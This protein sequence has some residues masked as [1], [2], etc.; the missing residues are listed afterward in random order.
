MKKCGIDCASG[1][2][3][4]QGSKVATVKAV[5]EREGITCFLCPWW[6]DKELE[7]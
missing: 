4:D 6:I 1:A 7:A 5:T 3:T 2:W